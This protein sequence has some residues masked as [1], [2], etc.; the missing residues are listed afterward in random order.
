MYKNIYL[1]TKEEKDDEKLSLI[2]DYIKE[3]YKSEVSIFS[4]NKIFKASENSEDTLFLLFLEDK[5][6]RLFFINHLSE[7]LSIAIL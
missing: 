2:I 5:G 3:T 4:E 6:I 1:I 7:N